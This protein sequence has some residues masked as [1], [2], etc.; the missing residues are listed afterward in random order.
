MT[1]GDGELIATRSY[2]IL[3]NS[4]DNYVIDKSSLEFPMNE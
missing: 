3:K 4:G 2:G 1:E